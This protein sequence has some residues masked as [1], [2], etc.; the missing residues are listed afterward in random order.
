MG[1][2]LKRRV[3]LGAG[4]GIP[5]AQ[6]TLPQAMHEYISVATWDPA[7]A[8]RVCVMSAVRRCCATENNRT[9]PSPVAIASSERT[10]S[11]ASTADS[12]PVR[13]DMTEQAAARNWERSRKSKWNL[14]GFC[15]SGGLS[16]AQHTL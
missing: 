15:A 8:V 11:K 1:G 6:F 3:L 2:S 9:R 13:E 5:P 7:A 16:L 14:Y 12:T 4:G 10:A